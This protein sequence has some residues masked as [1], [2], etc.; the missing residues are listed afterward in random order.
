MNI[1]NNTNIPLPLANWLVS[2]NYDYVS[3]D[4]YISVT[5]LLK[6]VKQIILSKRVDS[7]KL[8][9]DVEE[10]ISRA[11]GTALHDS[12]EK[13][14]LNNYSKNLKKLG[15]SENLIKRI[16]VNPTPEQLQS[17]DNPIPIYLEQ[18]SMKELNGWKI[19][20]KFDMVAEGVVND[21]KSTS[22][23]SWIHDNKTRDYQLQGSIYRWLNPDK[24][25]DDYIRI[26]FIFTDWQKVN[27]LSDPNYP[28]SRL[29]Y[30][31]IPLLSLEETER[32]ISSK[33]AQLD[34]YM[35]SP[36]IQ[37]PECSEEELWRSPGKYKYYLDPNK[38][39]GRSTKNFDNQMEA[40]KY[41]KIDK[42]G[43]GIV[44]YAP[45]EVKRCQYCSAASICKQ[46]L[47]YFEE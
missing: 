16:I 17:I 10:F 24:I 30:K 19:G 28:K 34:K 21:Y 6:P 47:K 14:W 35:N 5:S 38:T 7:D 15:Y 11:M 31:D 33:L 8:S 25:T 43:K 4:K 29:Q 13:S 37:I 27:S 3:D 12:I 39:S 44:I 40:N 23:Y 18:R 26:N 32:F 41:W 22:V 9:C 20:G 2:D 46:R 42:Q 36:E 45:G 1:T